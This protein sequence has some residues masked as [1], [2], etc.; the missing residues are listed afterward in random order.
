MFFENYLGYQCQQCPQIMPRCQDISFFNFIHFISF[1][2]VVSVTLERCCERA[3]SHSLVDVTCCQ[4]PSGGTAGGSCLVNVTV[5]ASPG[6]PC[7]KLA[8]CSSLN[9]TLRKRQCP[10]CHCRQCVCCNR[11][12]RYYL[13]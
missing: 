1:H 4:C 5:G 13:V 11:I 10:G 3:S 8:S 2:T 12:N 9:A 6:I 7:V